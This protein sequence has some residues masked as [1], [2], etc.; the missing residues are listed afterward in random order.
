VIETRSGRKFGF[1]L[2]RI[3]WLGVEF[4]TGT[5]VGIRESSILEVRNFASKKSPVE[6]VSHDIDQV[7]GNYLVHDKFG[8]EVLVSVEA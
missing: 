2:G 5:S 8:E 1:G 3:E 4:F 6:E 7:P